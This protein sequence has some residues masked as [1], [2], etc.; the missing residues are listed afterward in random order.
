MSLKHALNILNLVL[1]TL[2]VYLGVQSFYAYTATQFTVPEPVQ[3]PQSRRMVSPENEKAPPL[4]EYRSIVERNLFDTKTGEEVKPEPEPELLNIE[5]LKPTAL[6][7]KLWGTVINE[8][9]NAYAV[10]E[11]IQQREQNLY[12][13]GDTIQNATVKMILREKVIL[14]VGEKDEILEMEKLYADI[15]QRLPQRSDA[16]RTHAL[17]NIRLQRSTVDEAVQNVNSLLGQVRIR[18]YFE[19]GRPAGLSLSGIRSGSIFSQMGIQSGDIVKGV[20]GR[21]IESVDDVLKLYENLRSADQVQLQL[22][23]RGR[24]M[25]I[26]YAIE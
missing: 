13:V 8:G 14:Q 16:G 1:L 12:R 22:K 18:P 3:V 4:S 2:T 11:D 17:Q 20:N 21:D 5:E 25:N 19:N 6:N 24:D 26:N 9:V 15:Q 7:L 10:I 23:R